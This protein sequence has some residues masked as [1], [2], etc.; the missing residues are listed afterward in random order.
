MMIKPIGRLS[1]KKVSTNVLDNSLLNQK[2]IHSDNGLK[3]NQS[4]PK[5]K[6]LPNLS[7]NL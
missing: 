3:T 4:S 1:K 5:C 2:M 7:Y 6:K